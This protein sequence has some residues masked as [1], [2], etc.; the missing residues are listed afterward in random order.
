MVCPW[1]P[2]G[3]LTQPRSQMHGHSTFQSVPPPLV[4]E[5]Q[6]YLS[7]L[8]YSTNVVILL[9]GLIHIF[10]IFCVEAAILYINVKRRHAV[11]ATCRLRSQHENRIDVRFRTEA[12]S[13]VLLVHNKGPSVRDD[14]LAMA[15]VHGKVE[16]SY[17]LGKQGSRS[18]FVLKSPTLVSDGQ[19]HIASLDR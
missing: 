16:V 18:L 4:L 7:M 14:Y 3:V 13:G 2:L 17:N 1:T 12:D 5:L 10:T 15:V 9:V 8:C 19:W 6:W 11:S